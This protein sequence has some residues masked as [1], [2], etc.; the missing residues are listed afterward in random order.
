[1][2]VRSSLKNLKTRD[3]NNKLIKRKG[4]LYIINKKN[5]RMKA[6]QGQSDLPMEYIAI[7]AFLLGL[8]FTYT[9][10]EVKK[11]ENKYPPLGYFKNIDGYNIHYTDIGSGQPVVLLH[12]QPANERQFDLSL[13]HI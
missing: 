6:R 8:P 7:L 1:M 11:I 13:I 4:K 9:Q 3:R 10:L 2:K 12:S 5:P